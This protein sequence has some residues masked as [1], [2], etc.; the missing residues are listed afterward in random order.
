[1]TPPAPP[2]SKPSWR[3]HLLSLRRHTPPATLLSWSHTLS[4]LLCAFP[5]LQSARTI[6][7]YRPLPGELDLDPLAFPCALPSALLARARFLFPRC[8]PSTRTLSFAPAP[9]RDP[10]L[11]RVSSFGLCEPITPAADPLSIDWLIIPAL[12]C[13]HAGFRLGFG[14][15][16][17][18]RFLSEHPHLRAHTIAVLPPHAVLP[19]LPRDPWDI[20]LAFIATPDGITPSQNPY[21]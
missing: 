13:D 10:S 18:D 1:M 16:Y 4:L 15:G 7:S 2:Q 6:A 3:Q 12:A 8:A 19:S 17:Y 9:S 14:V 20:P 21:P 11:W 5:P